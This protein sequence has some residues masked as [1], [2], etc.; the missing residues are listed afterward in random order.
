MFCLLFFFPVNVY[1]FSVNEV[2]VPLHCTQT[3]VFYRTATVTTLNNRSFNLYL[4]YLFFLFISCLKLVL[5]ILTACIIVSEEICAVRLYI[6]KL[7]IKSSGI[8]PL[9]CSC[10]KSFHI[11][12]YLMLHFWWYVLY[13]TL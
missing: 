1:Y 13:M 12:G 4:V 6:S 2:P 5:L 8:K 11:P 9:L 3:S 10:L 7:K